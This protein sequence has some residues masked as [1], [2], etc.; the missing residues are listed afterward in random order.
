MGTSSAHSPEQWGILLVPHLPTACTPVRA[1]T[2][3]T[4]VCLQRGFDPTRHQI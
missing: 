1:L 2:C 4:T 3:E